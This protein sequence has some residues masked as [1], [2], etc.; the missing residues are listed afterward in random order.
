MTIEK[1]GIV[2]NGANIIIFNLHILDE[3]ILIRMK[4]KNEI[5][6]KKIG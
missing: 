1:E 6:D 2:T 3:A 4:R 5:D